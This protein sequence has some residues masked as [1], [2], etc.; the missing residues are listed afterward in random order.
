MYC[1]VCYQHKQQVELIRDEKDFFTCPDCG[2][3]VWPAMKYK[4]IWEPKRVK[5]KGGKSSKSGRFKN[6]KEVKLQPWY[7]R[8]LI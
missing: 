4:S 1:P 2:T 3:E 6:K 7:Q 5:V 8:S